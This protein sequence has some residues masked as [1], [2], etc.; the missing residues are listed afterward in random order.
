MPLLEVQGL[1]T[2]FASHQGFLMAVNDV[3]FSLEKGQTLGIVGESG[4]GKSVTALSIMRLLP[5]S[6]AKI[7]AG[8]IL[9]ENQDILKLSEKDMRS[10]RG[11]TL[12][13]IFQEAMTAL[14]PVF[15]I[16]N[17]I[18]EAIAL[19]QK[20]LNTKQVYNKAIEVLEKVGI[21]ETTQRYQE[22]PHQMSGGMRQRI[23]IA[24][25]LS[26]Q[27]Q[28]LIADEPTTALDVT[29]QAQVL[30]LIKELQKELG[31]A[32]ILIT[33]DLAVVAET[34][35]EV[36]VM[37]AGQIIEHAPTESLFSNPKHHYTQGLLDSIPRLETPQ[38]HQKLKTIPGFV[39]NLIN[40][41][42]GCRFQD[43]CKAVEKTC[44]QNH[45]PLIPSGSED[46]KVACFFPHT[47]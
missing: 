43:R 38:I 4:C 29:I 20:H 17:Q 10:M 21:S 25:A 12:S 7:Q 42:H 2:G 40:M 22:Y 33:H 28:L 11:N 24:M 5:S 34:C 19:H 39:P 41:P 31:M 14:N 23:M 45:P 18:S 3:S 6:S 8:K 15:T 16:G 36:A 13:M 27:P 1:K 30:K 35:D 47:K 46:H 26:C 37:Y 44:L 9:F 32:I